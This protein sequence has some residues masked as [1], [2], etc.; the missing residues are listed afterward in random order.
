MVIARTIFFWGAIFFYLSAGAQI[1][2]SFFHQLTPKEGLSDYENA[3]VHQD[4]QGFMWISSIDGL[5]RFDGHHVKVYRS[6]FDKSNALYGQNIQSNMYE[7]ASGNLWFCSYEAINQYHL[8]TDA[9]SHVR[10]V[11]PVTHDTIVKDY[12][13][14]HLDDDGLLWVMV[15]EISNTSIV[16]YDTKLGTTKF[17]GY[18]AANR[19]IAILKNGKVDGVLSWAYFGKSNHFAYLDLKSPDQNSKPIEFTY[20]QFANTTIRQAISDPNGDIWVSTDKGL[21]C[22]HQST[23]K[24]EVYQSPIG[25]NKAMKGLSILDN[26]YLLAIQADEGLWV[27]N[28][29]TKQ[30]VHQIKKTAQ[31]KVGLLSNN[32]DCVFTFRDGTV[33]VC[34]WRHGISYQNRYKQKISTILAKNLPNVNED[35]K[36]TTLTHDRSGNTWCGTTKSGIYIIDAN[37][38]HV[39]N[40]NIKNGLPSLHIKGLCVDSA[41]NIWV[42]T[43]K[44]IGYFAQN[45]ARFQSVPLQTTLSYSSTPIYCAQIAPNT[46]GFGGLGITTIQKRQD[47]TWHEI[48]IERKLKYVNS[49]VPWFKRLSPTQLLINFD[50]STT[51]IL[52]EN[53]A[54]VNLPIINPIG[55]CPTDENTDEWWIAS[56]YGLSRFCLKDYQVTETLNEGSGLLNQFLNSVMKDQEGKLWLPNLQGITVYD[57]ETGAQRII[58]YANGLEELIN[59]QYIWMAHP[60][61][62]FWAGSSNVLHYFYPDQMKAVPTMA[63]PTVT[64]L[65]INNQNLGN[66]NPNEIDSL[67]LRYDQNTIDFEGTAIEFAD[68]ENTL[69]RYRLE[70]YDDKWQELRGGIVMA[71]YVKLP[72][73][74]YTLVFETTNSD[75]IVNTTQKRIF[76]QIKPPFW[77]TWWFQIGALLLLLATIYYIYQRRIG[78]IKRENALFQQ[79]NQAELSALRA[80]INP[81]FLFNSLNSLNSFILTKNLDQANAYLGDFSKLMRLMLDHAQ[82]QIVT[83][84]EELDLNKLY[85]ELERRRFKTPFQF[86]FEIDPN[87]DPYDTFIPCMILQPYIENCIWHGLQHMPDG[88]SGRLL[89]RVEQDAKQLICILEDNGIGRKAAADLRNKSGRKDHKSHGLN[90]TKSRLEKQT[91]LNSIETIDLFD[92]TGTPVGTRVVVRIDRSLGP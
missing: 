70:G 33:W 91:G 75:G 13:V 42:A 9:F 92:Q 67:T 14:F 3:F 39:Q 32:P 10:L 7:S 58:T 30:Y 27:F 41:S 28:K 47:G 71:R 44:G 18:T 46:I 79:K 4:R 24:A 88:S 36:F 5:N 66:I 2:G 73:G 6:S 57:P 83:L 87:I 11:H 61:G 63:M 69:I 8:D 20:P 51:Q 25:A 35:T 56:T 76:I 50:L 82:K 90:I 40:L 77:K 19:A 34:D 37:G 78:Q 26:T 52:S 59:Q 86:T 72:A 38:N 16:T 89:V 15:G 81:H 55:A 22:I 64:L 12:N 53:S 29:I 80:F 85:I 54:P 48:E 31:N 74:K 68:P 1:P 23:S 21:I 65:K 45:D 84:Q 60:N 43:T 17:I 62:S 49:L